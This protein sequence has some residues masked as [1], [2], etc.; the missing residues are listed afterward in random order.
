MVTKIIGEIRIGKYKSLPFQKD[1]N[2]KESTNR[3]GKIFYLVT[4]GDKRVHSFGSEGKVV[5]RILYVYHRLSFIIVLVYLK[6]KNI[7]E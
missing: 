2:N 7:G 4:T 6:M 3:Y 1:L 5:R